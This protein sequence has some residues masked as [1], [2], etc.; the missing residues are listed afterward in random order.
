MCSALLQ[1]LRISNPF[2]T[3]RPGQESPQANHDGASGGVNSGFAKHHLSLMAVAR[4]TLSADGQPG[5]GLADTGLVAKVT[6]GERQ[7][8]DLGFQHRDRCLKLVTLT[9]RDT[10]G[11]ALD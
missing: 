10:H 2:T 6:K 7:I 8:F 5:Q 11:I 3:I 9:A 1:K 4:I